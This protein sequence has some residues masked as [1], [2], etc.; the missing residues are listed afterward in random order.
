MRRDV[1][2]FFAADVKSVYDAY[3][4]AATNAKFRRT[5]NQQPYHTISFNLNFSMKYNMN[6][7]ACTLHFMPYQNGTAVDLRFSIVQAI[8]ARYN[9]YAQDLTNDASVVLKL[10]YQQANVSVDEF[11]KAENQL[12]E[13]DIRTVSSGTTQSLPPVTAVAAAPVAAPV[14]VAERLCGNCGKPLVDGASFCVHCGTKAAK[15]GTFC[16][17]CGAAATADASFCPNCG[18]KLV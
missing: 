9:K 4:A 6:G 15:Q 18:T 7:G 8:G 5:C 2:Y 3:L 12:T 13:H 14:A 11:L 17:S 16:P 1:C 10:P